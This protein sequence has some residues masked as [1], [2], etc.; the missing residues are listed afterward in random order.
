MSNASLALNLTQR[1][2]SLW[3][4]KERSGQWVVLGI[5]HL[6]WAARP[7]W[8]ALE[9]WLINMDE[10][11][12]AWSRYFVVDPRYPACTLTKDTITHR[13]LPLPPQPSVQMNL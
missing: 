4:G 11:I 13:V 7:Y 12:A 6:H 3:V 8:G 10:R 5:W 9:L 2:R 1:Q